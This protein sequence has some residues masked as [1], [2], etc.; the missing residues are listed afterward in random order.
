MC[1]RNASNSA[2]TVGR[3]FD[4]IS[5]ELIFVQRI[6]IDIVDIVAVA[7]VAAYQNEARLSRHPFRESRATS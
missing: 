7:T 2:L 6:Q 4:C 5:L 1:S 3:I